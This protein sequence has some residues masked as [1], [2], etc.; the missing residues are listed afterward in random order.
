MQIKLLVAC[1]NASQARDLSDRI[2]AAGG[3]RIAADATGIGGALRKASDTR[4][5]VLLLEHMPP[6]Q[7]AAWHILSQLAAL[8][9][10]TRVLLLC[11]GYTDRAVVG[12]IQRGVSGCLLR[13]SDPA[14]CAK[15]VAAVHEGESWFGRATLLQALRSQISAEPAFTSPPPADQTL[16]TAREREIL[17]LIGSAMSNKEIAR[18][19]QISDKTVKTHLHHIY[20][21]LQRSGRYKAFVSNPVAAPAPVS[22]PRSLDDQSGVDRG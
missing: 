21:K 9:E 19:L 2:V 11:D 15:A 1:R 20:V 17:S 6:R 16:L 22:L 5:D 14:L 18:Q 7:Q 12:F 10:T 4:P 13:S 8:S 3:G